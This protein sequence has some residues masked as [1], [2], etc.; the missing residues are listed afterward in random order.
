M[1]LVDS[2]AD[3]ASL[4]AIALQEKN[5]HVRTAGGCESALAALAGNSDIDIDVSEKTFA[6]GDAL[7][8]HERM[9]ELPDADGVPFVI[10]STDTDPAGVSAA[11]QQ[12]IADYLFKSSGFAVTAVKLKNV[13]GQSPRAHRLRDVSGSLADMA[14][15]DI[16]HHLQ[17]GRVSGT[18]RI[19]VD[20]VAG[21]IGWTRGE[22]W[23]A[24][25]GGKTGEE[26]FYDMLSNTEGQFSI[27]PAR[28]P[29]DRSVNVSA[30]K[31]L[32]EGMRRLAT[33][34]P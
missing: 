14:L 18:L 9:S 27:D 25:W 30:K 8:L 31:M 10:L 28:I 5:F 24:R 2:N 22:I 3:E 4:L 16:V 1:L 17:Q 7:T 15:P 26:A 12:G 34:T 29:G 6:D 21:E 11:L 13:F 33:R 19:D 23:S 20:D 32:R